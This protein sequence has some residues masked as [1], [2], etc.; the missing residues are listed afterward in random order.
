MFFTM[1]VALVMLQWTYIT[2]QL[3]PNN[4][5]AR[6]LDITEVV[7]LAQKRVI[8]RGKSFQR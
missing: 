7:L 8:I 2:T 1:S 5:L 3:A 6:T 4:I